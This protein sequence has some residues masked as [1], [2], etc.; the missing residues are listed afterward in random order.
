[1]RAMVLA[2]LVLAMAGPQRLS[3]S[4]GAAKPVVL[5]ASLS[6]TP[7]M[8]AWE[9]DLVRSQLKLKSS[10]PA[11]IFAKQPMAATVGDALQALT[12]PARMPDR[13]ARRPPI[14]P[15]LCKSSTALDEAG[16]P[17]VLVTDGW[18]NQGNAAQEVAGLLAA[19]A[20]LYIFT[21]PGAAAIHNV[22]VSEVSTPH[23]LANTD[24]FR[25]GVTL[26]N[27]NDHPVAGTVR[28]FESGRL[29]EQRNLTLNPGS[30]RVDFPV[31]SAGTGLTSYRASFTASNPANDLY[32]QDDSLQSW[33]GIG[34]KRKMLIFAGSTQD[35][36]YLQ[37][38]GRRMGL[39]PEVVAP[40]DTRFNANLHSFDAVVLANVAR[41]QMPAATQN[42][43]AR[44]VAGGGALAMV[45]GDRELR[46]RADGTAADWKPSC[47]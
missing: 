14:W 9:A 24:S 43:L 31:R 35:A 29:I 18:E 8:R 28:L 3:T 44:Y 7:E 23:A 27:L 42:A 21:P 37:A 40:G 47:R 34:A 46:A 12:S 4:E 45:G 32:P 17:V 26:A 39:E 38:V 30:V 10:D 15:R 25:V 22:A 33:V 2:L 41:E 16:G 11:V 36:N 6:I 5:D 20:E 1:M 13:A 19:H